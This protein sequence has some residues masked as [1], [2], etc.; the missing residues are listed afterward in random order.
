VPD[1]EHTFY[2]LIKFV[3]IDIAEQLGGEIADE[4]PDQLRFKR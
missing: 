4:Q 1:A 2:K 3:E